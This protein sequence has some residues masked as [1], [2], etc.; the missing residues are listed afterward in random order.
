[1]KSELAETTNTLGRH[2][3]AETVKQLFSNHI[4][5]KTKSRWIKNPIP[6]SHAN[7]WLRIQHHIL[8]KRKSSN[9]HPNRQGNSQKKTK[10][11]MKTTDQDKPKNEIKPNTATYAK[12]NKNRNATKLQNG[13]RKT[14]QLDP[15]G[16][17]GRQLRHKPTQQTNAIHHEL[18]NTSIVKES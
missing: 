12:R 10:L 9:L 4:R 7:N 18:K 11:R 6:L 17:A 15:N 1:M 2:A 5:S 8:C 16:N 14:T 3:I 13:N